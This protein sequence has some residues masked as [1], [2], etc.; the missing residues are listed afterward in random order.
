MM[1][2]KSRII[3]LYFLHHGY[4]GLLKDKKALVITTRGG[5]YAGEPLDFQEPYLR[6]IF[7]FI[8]ITNITFIHAEN[9]AMGTDERQYA[10]A[11]AHKAIHQVI[12]AWQL[13]YSNASYW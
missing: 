5:N 10:I 3:L 13:D 2:V 8:G 1:G 9:L 11:A 6:A 12:A 4:E 7:D